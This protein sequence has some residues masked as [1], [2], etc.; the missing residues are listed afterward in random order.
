[1]LPGPANLELP[2]PN[3]NLG[4]IEGVR[5]VLVGVLG[6]SRLPFLIFE[7]DTGEPADPTDPADQEALGDGMFVLIP[8]PE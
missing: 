2:P 5:F 3:A 8:F 6:R 1:M 4:D 7:V